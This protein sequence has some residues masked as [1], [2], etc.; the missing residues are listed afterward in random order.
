MIHAA[1]ILSI[2]NHHVSMDKCLKWGYPKSWMVS[3]MENS[4][5]M[6]DSGV[7]LIHWPLFIHQRRKCCYEKV[8]FFFNMDDFLLLFIVF[9][10]YRPSYHAL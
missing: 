7:V 5:K 9:T 1:P 8:F 2:I 10:W 4:T 3:V 6:D